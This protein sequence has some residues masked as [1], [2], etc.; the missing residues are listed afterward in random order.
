LFD[1]LFYGFETKT[2]DFTLGHEL[3]ED[4]HGW[5]VGWLVGW[6]A[7]FDFCVQWFETK[8]IDFTPEVIEKRSLNLELGANKIFIQK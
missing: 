3:K 4:S 2:I 7:W 1:F 8:T 5:L 6:L